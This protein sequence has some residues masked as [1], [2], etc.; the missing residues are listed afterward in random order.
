MLLIS[1]YIYAIYSNVYI[2]IYSI[3]MLY[4]SM[5]IYAIYMFVCIYVGEAEQIKTVVTLVSVWYEWSLRRGD[6]L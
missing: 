2:A 5:Y 3:Y 1:M 4:I 6:K